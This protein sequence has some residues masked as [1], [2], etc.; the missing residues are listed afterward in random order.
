MLQFT[1]IS[2]RKR[3]LFAKIKNKTYMQ[4]L[5]VIEAKNMAL[6]CTFVD[7]LVTRGN[8][9]KIHVL[10]RSQQLSGARGHP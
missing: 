1:K 9:N 6:A 3:F 10:L 8:K 5:N 2:Y 4:N 7:N